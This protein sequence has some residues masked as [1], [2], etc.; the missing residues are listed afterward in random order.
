MHLKVGKFNARMNRPSYHLHDAEG[1]LREPHPQ[2]G[3]LKPLREDIPTGRQGLVP[4]D[5]TRVGV[6]GRISCLQDL[7]A[8]R[9][10]GRINPRRCDHV[11]EA[12]A[13]LFPA[14]HR[15]QTELSVIK[16]YVSEGNFV[17]LPK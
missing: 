14:Q 10:E 15:N 9:L 17:V 1:G 8:R 3:E 11:G 2:P 5:S 6:E 4:G 16:F 13:L 12:V 7:E